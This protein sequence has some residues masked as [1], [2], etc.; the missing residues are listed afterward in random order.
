[1]SQVSGKVKV[2]F[3]SDEPIYLQIARQIGELV[4]TGYLNVGDQLPTVREMAAELSINF[5]TVARAYRLLDETRL[6][7][8]Q[9]GRGTYIW[10]KPTLE[11]IKILKEE[12]LHM[13]LQK[14]VED[15]QNLGYDI[16]DT[17]A[18]LEKMQVDK[19]NPEELEKN[20]KEKE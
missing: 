7:S 9:R 17:I 19:S 15:A 11:T 3:R 10:E 6:I 13:M 5:N 4:E 1:M 18:V 2:N 20:I 14:L 8:T 16:S 12:A